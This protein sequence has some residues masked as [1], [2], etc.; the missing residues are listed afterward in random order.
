MDIEVN[1]KNKKRYK[2]AKYPLKQRLFWIWLIRFLSKIMLIGKEYKV[3]KVN[4][5]GLKPPYMMLSNHMHF[6]DF[7]LA[8]QA[9]WPHSVS[10][11]VSIDGY[12]IKWFLLEWIGAICTRKYT[13]DLHLIKSIRHVL[14]RG[15]I[16]SM[17]PEARYTPCGTTSF[18]P[19]SL[20]KLVKMNK[21]P[22]VTV[23]HRGNHL[24]AP[25]WNFRDKRRVPLH[26]TFTQ[27]LTAEQ[28]SEMSVEEINQAIKNA[29]QYDDYR[30]QKEN[31][32]KIKE[33]TRAEGFGKRMGIY[34]H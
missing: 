25:F 24:Y 7:E 28:V 17:Y 14:K 34:V 15:D 2:T 31:G 11:V 9:T 6:I 32:I 1:Y 20:G 26:T 5:E 33:A 16:L 27:L 29:L 30:Y 22:V 10:N 3:E 18:L 21:V 13:N 4:M 8:A 12:V 23:I 19:E